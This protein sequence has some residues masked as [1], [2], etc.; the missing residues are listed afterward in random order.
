MD[1]PVEAD[2]A[3]L[4]DAIARELENSAV[5]VA[6]VSAKDFLRGRSVRLEY[7]RDD[8]D[9]VYD[10]YYDF[11]AL[12]REV[13]DALLPDG[14]HTWLPRLRDP[15]TDRSVRVS[16][17]PAPP[18]TVAV[19]DGRFLTRDDIRDGFDLIV[20]L[21]VSAPALGRRL[22]PEEATRVPGAWSRYLADDDPARHAGLVA[23]FDHPDRP[24]LKPRPQW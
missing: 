15:L 21:D 20:H 6:R 7:G 2:T 17:Q 19:V 16:P 14:R 23:R 5:P 24:A 1:G 9:A 8:P 22:P 12:R 18:G 11:P 4:A 13:L 3:R 10:L